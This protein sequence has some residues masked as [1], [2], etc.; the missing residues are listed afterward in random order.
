MF[1][2]L[3]ALALS[4]MS[5]SPAMQVSSCVPSVDSVCFTADPAGV[6][7]IPLSSS[8]TLIVID[9]SLY[10]EQGFDA[11]SGDVIVERYIGSDGI[12]QDKFE[13]DC[14]DKGGLLTWT[15][16]FDQ[17]GEFVCSPEDF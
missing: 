6:T 17:G 1:T 2:T 15:T 16:M 7:R 8:T 14:D 10:T 4:G 13:A 3:I 11:E 12:E 9:T 5:G